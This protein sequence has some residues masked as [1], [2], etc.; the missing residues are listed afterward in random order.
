MGTAQM[1]NQGS[2]W[3]TINWNFA[4]SIQKIEDL[5]LKKENNYLDYWE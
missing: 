3:F 1:Q 5:K 2:V 4:K